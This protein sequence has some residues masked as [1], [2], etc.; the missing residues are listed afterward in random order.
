MPVRLCS[1]V[2]LRACTGA[3][4]ARATR[5]DATP[6]ALLPAASGPSLTFSNL[7]VTGLFSESGRALA[8]GYRLN[9]QR[10]ARQPVP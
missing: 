8:P 9:S 3:H 1:D 2:C 7:R 4:V 6:R 5:H 10:Q